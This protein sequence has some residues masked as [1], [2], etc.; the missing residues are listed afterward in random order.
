MIILSYLSIL[1]VLWRNRIP[2]K[3]M[4][5]D[6][7]LVK[8]GIQE[9]VDVSW[10]NMRKKIEILY[11]SALEVCKPYKLRKFKKCVCLSVYY[12]TLRWLSLK[13]KINN[14]WS[15][16]EIRMLTL[17][18]WECQVVHPLGNQDGS[19]WKRITISS[20]TCTPRYMPEVIESRNLR[21]ARVVHLVRCLASAQAMISWFRCSSTRW[22]SVLIVWSL[23]GILYLHPSLSAPP[24]LTC[25]LF[26]SKKQTKKQGLKQIFVYQCSQQHY[27]KQPE[28]WNTTSVHPQM[29]Q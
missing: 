8:L 19:C 20:S 3:K 29:N 9:T 15:S 22:G 17:C 25:A 28:G 14:C 7:I 24:Q 16:G 4:F 6:Q 10:G 26:L 1:K 23:L 18:W 21:G 13:V 2:N 5:N 12:A 11:T 27:A